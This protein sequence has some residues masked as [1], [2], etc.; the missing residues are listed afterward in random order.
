MK[1]ENSLLKEDLG[2]SIK[3]VSSPNFSSPLKPK[4]LVIH[5]TAGPSLEGTV[6]WFA[7]PAAQASA[8]IVIGRDGEIVQMVSFDK[9]AW[10]AGI[11]QWG[12]LQG[13]NSHSIGIELV[14]AGK[15]SLNGRKEWVSWSKKVIPE[16]DVTVATHKN[17]ETESGWHEYT[18]NQLAALISVARVLHAAYNFED[19]LGHD[20]IAPTR[21]VD[22]GPLFP[23][24][25]FRSAILGRV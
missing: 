24:E 8:H 2:D 19:I 20:D 23:M 21:K 10:H 12:P 22:P 11:S 5:Y 9:K 13:L 7:D 6:S 1:I 18:E 3:F 15:L 16:E 4:Y 14:N 25:S 17:E